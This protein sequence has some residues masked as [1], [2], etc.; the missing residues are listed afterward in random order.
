MALR[1]V[2]L[3]G[4]PDVDVDSRTTLW[5]AV[6][7]LSECLAR[8]QPSPQARQ[9]VVV[10]LANVSSGD[11]MQF[12][13]IVNKHVGQVETLN[14]SFYLLYYNHNL[15]FD[16]SVQQKTLRSRITALSWTPPAS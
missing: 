7:K 8:F 1:S 13:L 2:T 10:W 9:G 11:K 12:N 3:S 15:L 6:S 4:L 14:H 16:K 5:T